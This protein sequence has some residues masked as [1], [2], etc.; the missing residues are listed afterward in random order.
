MLKSA[1]KKGLEAA[2]PRVAGV[3][4]R[5]EDV[6]LSPLSGRGEVSGLFVGS[7]EGFR[8]GSVM[9]IGRAIVVA[10]PTTFLSEKLVIRS[11]RVEEAIVTYETKL[12]GSNL[13]AIERAIA[14]TLGA[15]RERSNGGEPRRLQVDEFVISGGRVRVAL[16]A[17]GG[18]GAIRNLPEIRMTDLGVEGQGITPGELAHE[19]VREIVRATAGVVGEAALDI[20]GRLDRAKEGVKKVFGGE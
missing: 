20:G 14:E 15:G 16:T 5:V 19:V 10:R 1:F 18:K 3:A 7:P 11:V 13:A 6:R 9:E 17:L 12:G 8:A 4:T 2:G